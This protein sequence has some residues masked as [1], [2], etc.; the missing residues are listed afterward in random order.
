[1]RGTFARARDDK[2]SCIQG[3]A[4]SRKQCT[5]DSQLD[6]TQQRTGDA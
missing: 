6:D 4:S 1:M 3:L 2:V 5:H